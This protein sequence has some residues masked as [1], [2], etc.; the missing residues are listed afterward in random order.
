MVTHV[1]GGVFRIMFILVLQSERIIIGFLPWCS[2]PELKGFQLCP[3]PF[4]EFAL[5]ISQAWLLHRGG[6][7]TVSG[8]CCKIEVGVLPVEDKRALDPRHLEKGRTLRAFC[9]TYDV[10]L[11]TRLVT[12]PFAFRF[13]RPE[14]GPPSAQPGSARQRTMRG[15][16]KHTSL[17][18][19][20]LTLKG[21]GPFKRNIIFQDP[22]LR[23]HVSWW[24]GTA[25]GR[26]TPGP[27]ANP[28][29][30]TDRR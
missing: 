28:A 15:L 4:A 1:T 2:F 13:A 3:A 6:Y 10:C 17:F 8:W 18:T 19:W 7:Q 27:L 20:N 11:C 29:H 21:P 5:W 26:S 16:A 22:S 25:Y 23:F 12:T 14:A 24:E 9:Y 30:K